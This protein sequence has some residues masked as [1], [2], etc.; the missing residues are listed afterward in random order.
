M[1]EQNKVWKFRKTDLPNAKKLWRKKSS[2]A[3]T[4]VDN[5]QPHKYPYTPLQNH[6]YSKPKMAKRGRKYLGPSQGLHSGTM[7][8]IQRLNIVET[9]HVAVMQGRNSSPIDKNNTIKFHQNICLGCGD[10]QH[11]RGFCP[12]SKI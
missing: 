11:C 12:V 1:E 9:I 6:C 10:T 7:S 4:K 5:G 2:T 3:I 8:D